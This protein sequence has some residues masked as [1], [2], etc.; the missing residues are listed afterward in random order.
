MDLVNSLYSS[1]RTTEYLEA[2]EKTSTREIPTDLLEYKKKY[3]LTE[4][5]LVLTLFDQAG[6]L[7]RRKLIDA[8]L[9]QDF[10]GPT[11]IETWEKYKPLYEEEERRLNR[12]HVYQAVEYLY[13]ELK[14]REQQRVSKTT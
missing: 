10:F 4:L 2:W 7:L 13:N 3:G 12:P 5:R 8:E 6:I 9:V 14:K 1:V 11:V